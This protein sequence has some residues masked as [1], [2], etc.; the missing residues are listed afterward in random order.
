MTIVANEIGTSICK[1]YNQEYLEVLFDNHQICIEDVIFQIL[2]E[3][4]RYAYLSNAEKHPITFYIER[5]RLEQEPERKTIKRIIDYVNERYDVEEKKIKESLNEQ[6]LKPKDT[7]PVKIK[8]N[9]YPEYQLSEF[10]YWELKNIHDMDIVKAIIEKRIGS[11]KKVKVDRFIEMVQQYDEVIRSHKEKFLKTPEDTVFSSMV[12]FALQSRYSLDFFYQISKEME[13][14]GVKSIPDQYNRL[15]TMAGKYKC[16]SALP[17]LSP[18]YAHDSDRNIEYPPI[19]QRIRF[20]KDMVSEQ[21]DETLFGRVIEFNVLSNAVQSHI[22]FN[23][24]PMRTWFLKNTTI[25][26]WASV[27]ETYNVF[28]TFVPEKQWSEANIQAVRKMY[29]SVSIDYKK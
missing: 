18:E 13:Q 19:I 4:C 3:C 9:R 26:D 25:D 27:F 7:E 17:K 29:D 20:V 8:N 5:D 21:A 11:S 10:A 15:M 2:V 22:Y 16:T 1:Y 14:E 24:L 23:K 28:R 12:L 6:V